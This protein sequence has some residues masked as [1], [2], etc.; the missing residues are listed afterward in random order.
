MTT[1]NEYDM[2]HAGDYRILSF[3]FGSHRHDVPIELKG[4][5]DEIEIFEAIGVPYLTGNFTMKDDMRF[6]DGV[7]INGT[8]MI[9]ITL[10]S[11]EN[12][13][14]HLVKKFHIVEINAGAKR[15]DNI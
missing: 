11:P 2:Q 1:G 12:P 14:K 6:Y 4:S 13:D 8:E 15:E 3:L 10:Q 9:N 7:D 5:I